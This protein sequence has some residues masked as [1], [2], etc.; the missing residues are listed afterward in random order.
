MRV[1]CPTVG[2]RPTISHKLF[3]S[4]WEFTFVV[5][6]EET[7]DKLAQR[8]R[9]DREWNG[10]FNILVVKI[11][12]D[13]RCTRLAEIRNE[14]E[15][16]MNLGEWFV[17]VDDDCQGITQLAPLMY[18]ASDLDLD[19][20]DWSSSEWHDWFSHRSDPEEVRKLIG[21]LLNPF[22]RK[23]KFAHAAYVNGGLHIKRKDGREW[24]WTP[25]EDMEMSCYALRTYGACVVNRWAHGLFKDSSEGGGSTFS[26]EW[27]MWIQRRIKQMMEEYPGLLK[28]DG[29]R[30][31]I[32]KNT[33]K[34]VENWRRLNGWL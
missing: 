23:R 33:L 21:D 27:E 31:K 7:R 22:Y 17:E 9:N 15:A 1:F 16:Q 26:P 28:P 32:T 29:F 4:D 18:N 25:H 8:I 11:K 34:S 20:D 24:R 2:E 13:R 3:P 10:S 6:S 12:D 14:I 19:Y 5:D 30:V